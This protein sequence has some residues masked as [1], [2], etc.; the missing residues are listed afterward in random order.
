[1]IDYEEYMSEITEKYKKKLKL[2]RYSSNTQRNY[3]KAFQYFVSN[4]SDRDI[5]KLSKSEIQEYLFDQIEKGLSPSLQNQYINA[6]KFYYEKVLGR[7]KEIYDL[8]RPRREH[9]LPTVLSEEEIILIL[10]QV[11]NLKHKSILYLIYSSGIRVSELVNLK[12]TDIDS[13]RNLILIRNSKGKKDRTTLLSQALLELLRKYYLKY[14]PKDYLF[15]GQKGGKYS[16]RSVQNIL[17][18]ALSKSGIKK[19]ATVHTL[20]HSFATHLLERGTDLRYIQ[21]LLGHSN[22]K[23]TEIYT[24]ITK[25]GLDK[26]VSPLDNLIK[27]GKL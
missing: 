25:R 6:I 9:K 8:P 12:I 13:N 20:R 11:S 14:K 5:D 22:S 16:T 27:A 1:M 4:F 19:H 24:H 17:K 21:E 7:K 18:M 26:I 2:K 23:T 3:Q 15:E 10:N